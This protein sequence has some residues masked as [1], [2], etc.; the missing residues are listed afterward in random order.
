[1]FHSCSKSMSAYCLFKP[2]EK[3][4]S[5]VSRIPTVQPKRNWGKKKKAAGETGFSCSA[6]YSERL[7]II[8]VISIYGKFYFDIHVSIK[9]SKQL[10][11]LNHNLLLSLSNLE[12]FEVLPHTE[13]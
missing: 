13:G 9:P 7:K 5:I 11:F 2:N 1:M 4:Y 12:I 3:A 6:E 10:H 8:Y